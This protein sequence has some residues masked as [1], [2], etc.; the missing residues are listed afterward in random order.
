LNSEIFIKESEDLIQVN[1]GAIV[2]SFNKTGRELI[3]EI[4]T[5]STNSVSHWTINT[6]MSLGLIG[7]LLSGD[8]HKQYE[9]KEDSNK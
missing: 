6:I 1:T 4:K 7:E 3:S 8:F 2:C 9:S 5:T